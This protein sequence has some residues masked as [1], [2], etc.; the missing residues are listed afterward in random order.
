ML[1]TAERR[2]MGKAVVTGWLRWLGWASTAA[3]AAAV[4][5]MVATWF[6]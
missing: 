6:A 3:M 1:M 2:V 4:A 5:G